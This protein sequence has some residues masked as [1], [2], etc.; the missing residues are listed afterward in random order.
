[1]PENQ[2]LEKI[3]IE[4][5]DELTVFA[6]VNSSSE[7]IEY[8]ED[9]LED[10]LIECGCSGLKVL[11]AAH[12]KIAELFATNKA[13]RVMLGHKIDAAVD[14]KVSDDLLTAWLYIKSA[15]GGNSPGSKELVDALNS[16]E[17]NLNLVDKKKI[18]DLVLQSKI[19]EPGDSVNAVIASGRAPIHG[20]DTQ[21][22]CL[23]ENVSDRR[24]SAR[25]DGSLD[26]YDLGEIPCVEAGVE[27]MKQV[28]P[29]PGKNGHSVTGQELKA[30]VGKKIKFSKCIGAEVSSADPEV[31]VSTLKGQPI[32]SDRGVSVENIHIVKNVDIHTGHI[33]FDGSLV[34]KG[35]V[36]SGMKIKVT[37]D[38][39]IFGVVENASI[40]AGGNIDIKLGAIGQ[41]KSDRYKEKMQINCDGNL[42][43][44]QLENLVANVKGDIFVK[45]RISNCEVK[46]GHQV[47]VGNT[48]Q[49][50][51]GI[52]GGYITAGSVIRAEVLGSSAGTETTVVIACSDE[53]N[54]AFSSIKTEIKEEKEL[55]AK[56]LDLGD[57]LAKKNSAENKE[58]FV[59]VKKDTKQV[60]AKVNESIA[61]KYA[62][63]E[64]MEHSSSGKI[65]VQKEAH[66]GVSVRIM[67]KE[68]NVKTRFGKGSFMLSEG[69]MAFNSD[70]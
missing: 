48:Q 52:V 44:G 21:F 45:S 14:V 7:E 53:I 13:G 16:Q 50:K 46:A 38:V 17:L 57:A 51:S 58:L 59:M 69:V 12:E 5:E 8:S 67:L 42:T 60:K 65:M 23:L 40:D 34:V 29:L 70:L 49:K 36:A 31:L 39:Q 32:V 47:I 11:K 15:E 35:D 1:M 54:N 41:V 43:A 24:P 64:A 37:G 33:D 27:L 66:Q 18:I 6:V 4:T 22:E 28:A 25:D 30:Y 20:K 62:I 56:M 26:Y 19:V 68:Q 63:E 61:Q 2:T 3:N 55:L 9:W 10:R